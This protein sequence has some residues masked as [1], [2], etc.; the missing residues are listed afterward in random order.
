MAAGPAS[1]CHGRA[2]LGAGS[3]PNDLAQR[4]SM[5]MA[6][7][8]RHDSSQQRS[9]GLRGCARR[10]HDR[11]SWRLRR[12]DVDR[13]VAMRGPYSGPRAYEDGDGDVRRSSS[14]LRSSG[15][16]DWRVR[17]AH[18]DAQTGATSS[19]QMRR[20]SPRRSSAG[21]WRR[22]ARSGDFNATTDRNQFVVDP[23][24]TDGLWPV[25]GGRHSTYW[26]PETGEVF[27]WANPDDV[28]RVLREKRVN[29]QRRASIGVLRV[30][31]AMGG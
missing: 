10:I 29:Q 19:G 4:P 13:T 12:A 1:C 18:P 8:R 24:N 15:L 17:P 14:Q 5:T 9:V 26:T 30:P 21:S 16:G 2:A 6:V 7:R 20:L 25:F 3:A 28:A 22:K 27:A 11:A 31:R 23:P